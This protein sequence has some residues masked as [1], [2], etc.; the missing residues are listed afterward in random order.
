MLK[1][2]PD[3]TLYME[4]IFGAIYGSD[5]LNKN[6]T[7]DSLSYTENQYNGNKMYYIIKG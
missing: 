6:W 7:L 3:L 4:N 1:D 2:F 5:T